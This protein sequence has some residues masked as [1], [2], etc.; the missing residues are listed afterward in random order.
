MLR[1]LAAARDEV[2]ANVS[3]TT[4][5]LVGRPGRALAEL[6]A[7]AATTSSSAAAARAGGCGAARL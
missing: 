4:Q 3:L 6:A 5:V 1:L 7:T 2:P